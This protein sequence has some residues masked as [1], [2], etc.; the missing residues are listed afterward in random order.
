VN[1]AAGFAGYAGAMVDAAVKVAV[2]VAL[3]A[4]VRRLL[5]AGSRLAA[6]GVAIAAL[7][8]LPA[9]SLLFAG[10][11]LS[12][13]PDLRSFGLAGIA[14]GRPAGQ[15]WFD[16]RAWAS[17]LVV[18]W[19]IGTAIAGIRLV[20]GLRRL[21]RIAR[22]AE[23]FAVPDTGG[24]VQAR[25]R[26]AGRPA[27]ILASPEVRVPLTWGL[28]RPVILLPSSARGWSGDR[29]AAVIRHESE[30]AR[31]GD[32]LVQL[33]LRAIGGLHWLNPPVHWA[34][35]SIL[36][37]LESACDERV[38]RSGLDPEEYA[39]HLVEIARQA[40]ARDP[41]PLPAIAAVRPRDLE[42]RVRAILAW[43]PSPPRGAR[44]RAATAALLLAATSALLGAVNPWACRGGPCPF[45]TGGVPPA[46]S[47]P[48]TSSARAGSSP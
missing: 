37:D 40:K 7:A 46:G 27:R 12:L 10:F 41:G 11:G 16:A 2:L 20:L 39:R 9:A 3:F 38:L 36:A 13:L 25:A 31:R 17:W 42:R 45:A 24:R 23:P 28:C 26:A 34:L 29:L 47:C 33:A 5:P 1:A 21:G 30:H 22:A 18:A 44:A 19:L 35:R 6:G 14:Y 48:E 8:A 4:A 43:P 32:W 15:P